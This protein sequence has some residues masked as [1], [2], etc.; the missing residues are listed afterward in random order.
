MKKCF[1]INILIFSINIGFS[2]TTAVISGKAT[3]DGRPLLYKNRDTTTLHSRMV[4]SNHGKYSFIGMTNPDD[5]DNKNILNGHNSAGFAIMNSDSYNLNYPE[6]KENQRQ[7][8]EIMRLALESCSTLKDFENLLIHLPKPLRLSSN[9]GVIDAQ[10]GAAYYE[11]SNLGFVKY[12]ANN[13]NIAPFGYIIRTN[14]S[15]S[16]KSEG[17]KGYSR[18]LRAQELLYSA[19]LTNSLTPKYFLQNV[20]RSLVH[21]LTKVDLTKYSEEFSAFRD[22]IPRYYTASVVVIQGVKQTESPLLTTAWTILGTSLGSVA[23][24]LWLNFNKI[25][26][27]VLTADL[28]NTT[29]MDEWASTIKKKL[30]P[31][32]KGEG[33]DYIHVPTLVSIKPKLIS[34]E[35]AIMEQSELLLNKWRIED[36]INNKELINFYS[37]VDKYI[38]DKYFPLTQ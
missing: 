28:N 20:S 17:G 13:P 19:S 27:K 36:K 30:F 7:D 10:G 21:G 6:I 24:P 22:F 2:C 4:Y 11:T 16:G 15:F 37:W 32:E 8:G 14:Y 26:P 29:L 33:S 35:N 12:D 1:L 5:K 23:I 18:F 38:H 31:I 34:I 9:F 3:P 25:F